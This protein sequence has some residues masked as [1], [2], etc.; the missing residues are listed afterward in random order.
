MEKL[1]LWSAMKL[2]N[3]ESYIIAFK[4]KPTKIYDSITANMDFKDEMYL[5][6]EPFPIKDGFLV[7]AIINLDFDKVYLNTGTQYVV[8][9]RMIGE[10]D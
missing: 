2:P 10:Y 3:S 5:I 6:S 1:T 9:G 8:S 4:G 7:E